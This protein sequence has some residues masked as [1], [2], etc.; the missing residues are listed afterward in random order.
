M[1]EIFKHTRSGT[2]D[3]DEASHIEGCVNIDI[4]EINTSLSKLHQ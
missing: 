3:E 1:S 4:Q 2:P